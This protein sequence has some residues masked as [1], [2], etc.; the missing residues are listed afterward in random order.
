MNLNPEDGYPFT[1]YELATWAGSADDQA[2][3]CFKDMDTTM[4][5]FYG[6][7]IEKV[8]RNIYPVLYVEATF[9]GGRYTLMT[10]PQTVYVHQNVDKLY[11][12][13]KATAHIPLGIFS[14]MSGY[15]DDAQGQQWV[16]TLQIFRNKVNASRQGLINGDVGVTEGTPLYDACSDILTASL[17]FIDDIL[18]TFMF[19]LEDFSSYSRALET[20][21]GTCQAAAA[22]NQV[23]VMTG[24]LDGWK[25]MIGQEEWNNMYVMISALWTLTVEN[26]HAL[27]IKS[28]MEAEYWDTNVLVSEAIPTLDDAR[29][30]LG[31][32]VGDRIMAECVFDPAGSEAALQ[33]IYSLSTE[34][35]LLSQAIEAVIPNQLASKAAIG[36]PHLNGR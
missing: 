7:N 32:V 11:D 20:Q 10:G 13:A 35:D 1:P 34:R 12:V 4:R 19:T 6:D 2:F 28:T 22:Q 24:V 9:D 30:L 8:G 21:I 29:T 33:N 3:Q 14:I 25:A 5:V 15:A 17:Y 16:P 27:I 31:R 18:A 36:C 23:D 26:A